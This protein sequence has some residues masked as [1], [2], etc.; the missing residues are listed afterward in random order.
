VN[1]IRRRVAATAAG[2]A[3]AIQLVP[4]VATAADPVTQTFTFTGAE[5]QFSVP[6]NVTSLHVVLVG[7]KG[8]DLDGDAS[9]GLGARVEADLAVVPGT[10]LYVEV[11]GN[12]GGEGSSPVGGFNGGGNGGSCTLALSVAAGGGGASDIRTAPR[13]LAGTLASR[14]IVAGA[15][16]GRGDDGNGG[17]AGAAGAGLRAGGAGTLVGGGA[18]ASGGGNGSLGQGGDG[19]TSNFGCGA[20]GGGGYYGGGGGGATTN[21]ISGGAGG[22]GS[23]F[24]GAATNA[25]VDADTTG[26][27]LVT[28]S[29]GG[30]T[31]DATVGADVNVKT[32]AACVELS[33]SQVSFG[34]LALGD[35]DQPATPAITVTNCSGSGESLLMSGTDATGTGASW[36]LAGGP[37]TCAD[38]LGLDRY[39]LRLDDPTL[40]G[41]VE[42]STDP[43]SFMTLAGGATSTQTA[44]IYMACPGSSGAGQT[45]NMSINY[46]AVQP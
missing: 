42:L 28:I 31:E 37:E 24:T 18:G 33:T 5:Q 43:Q 4:A 40:D 25:L 27:S 3:L 39:R 16:G 32:S 44:R 29:T 41:A 38:T 14:L 34:T 1:T 11:G 8:G 17:A 10:T 35:Q 13:A 46:L 21:V 45:M 30:G 2:A 19:A 23:S 20:G 26:V 22:G 15:G 9:G 6:A 12:G 36:A 7:G